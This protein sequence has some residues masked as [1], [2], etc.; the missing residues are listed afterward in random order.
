MNLTRRNLWR[1]AAALAGLALLLHYAP[2]LQR[3][4][5]LG[6]PL[7]V[8]FGGTLLFVLDHAAARRV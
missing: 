5:P 7:A 2:A 3:G 8:C 4:H 1:L 6:V